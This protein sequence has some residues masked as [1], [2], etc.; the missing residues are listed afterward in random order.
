VTWSPGEPEEITNVDFS[1]LHVLDHWMFSSECQ[2]QFGGWRRHLW[3]WWLM[4]GQ[5]K[6]LLPFWR[7]RCLFG[8]HKEAIFRVVRADGHKRAWVGC[9]ACGRE[10][11]PSERELEQNPEIRFK[12]GED[13]T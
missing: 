9:L 2:R 3:V 6:V 13:E 11:M 8:V 12:I 10:R 1:E 7:V 5:E 4:T